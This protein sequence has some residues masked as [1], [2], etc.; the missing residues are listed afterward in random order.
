MA[1]SHKIKTHEVFEDE[2][3]NLFFFLRSTHTNRRPPCWT[4]SPQPQR[5]EASSYTQETQTSP[6]L[7]QKTNKNTIAV[8]DMNEILPPEEKIKCFSQLITFKNAVQVVFDHRMNCAWVTC[9]SHRQKLTS[10]NTQHELLDTWTMTEEMR[11]NS[12][13]HSGG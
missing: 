11:R 1:T 3:S 7:H 8:Q 13:L 2:I 9:T 6:T 12:I 4:T 10:P 5:Q